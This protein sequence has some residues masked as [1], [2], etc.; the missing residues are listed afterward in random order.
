MYI[1]N[2][3]VQ[4]GP[5]VLFCFQKKNLIGVSKSTY[6]N[7]TYGDLGR[8]PMKIPRIIISITFWIKI[9]EFKNFF[10]IKRMYNVR[11]VKQNDVNG[12]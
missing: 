12:E 3:D 2:A 5:T 7:V 4:V 8:Y 11:T 10:L 1:Y 6:L 9:L